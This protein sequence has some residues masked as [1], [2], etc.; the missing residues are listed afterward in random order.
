MPASAEAV[1]FNSE[2]H[3][4]QCT[5]GPPPPRWTTKIKELFLPPPAAQKTISTTICTLTSNLHMYLSIV[6][7]QYKTQN[8]KLRS[9]I[10][11]GIEG[12]HSKVSLESKLCQLEKGQKRSQVLGHG[13]SNIGWRDASTDIGFDFQFR[14][15]SSRAYQWTTQKNI[16]SLLL[17]EILSTR[18]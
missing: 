7:T 16:Y 9:T 4:L 13:S 11:N 18:I 10:S 1:T 2:N 17:I 3:Y 5:L 6:K 15:P 8:C 12:N 14:K